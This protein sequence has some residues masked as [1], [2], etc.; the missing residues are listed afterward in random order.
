MHVHLSAKDKKKRL[1]K[2]VVEAFELKYPLLLDEMAKAI[3]DMAK[4]EF[5]PKTGKLRAEVG[6]K[7]KDLGYISVRVPQELFFTIRRFWP[8]FGDDSA[9]LRL[10]AEEFPRLC[11]HRGHR[12]SGPRTSRVNK[13]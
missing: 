9:D 1:I 13:T 10:V 8:D 4:H 11:H 2:A 3:E 12:N 7:G 5:D 6:K